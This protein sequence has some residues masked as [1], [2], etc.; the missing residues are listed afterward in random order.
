MNYLKYWV[1]DAARK[2]FCLVETTPDAE[3]AARL[4]QH[5]PTTQRQ[6]SDARH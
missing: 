6:P 2:V 5:P 3:S 1:D 4:H